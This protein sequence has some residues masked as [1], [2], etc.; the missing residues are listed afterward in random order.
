MKMAVEHHFIFLSEF[1]FVW[2]EINLPQRKPA[3][4]VTKN[5]FT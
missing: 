1:I 4:N 2:S 5:G 3:I